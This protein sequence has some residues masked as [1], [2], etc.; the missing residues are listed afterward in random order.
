MVRSHPWLLVP[1]LACA[2]FMG[3]EEGS[4]EAPSRPAPVVRAGQSGQSYTWYD[5]E[6]PHVAMAL[7]DVPDGSR[8]HVRVDLLDQAPDERD[9]NQ[10]W[11]AD[12][13]EPVADGTYSV[14][15]MARSAF[16][17]LLDEAGGVDFDAPAPNEDVVLYGA[18]WCGAC[19]AAAAYF[20]QNDVPFVEHDIEEDPGAREEMQAKARAAGVQPSGIPV[21][22]VRGTLL[23]GFDQGRIA[24]LLQIDR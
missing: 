11:V 10:V 22:D 14:Q 18:S 23:T 8:Q 6:G 13:R 17:A 15:A 19:R 9:P 20:R 4:A 16:D 3:C 7:A 5:D 1:A 24:Q 2:I 21:I 12:L